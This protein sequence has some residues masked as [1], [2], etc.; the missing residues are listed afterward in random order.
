[1]T[2]GRVKGYPVMT[3][4]IRNPTSLIKSILWTIQ[5]IDT[6]IVNFKK[7]SELYEPQ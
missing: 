3:T 5:Q 6:L 7:Y 4:A 1:M 2:W